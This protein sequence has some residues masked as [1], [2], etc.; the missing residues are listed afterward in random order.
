MSFR[1][2]DGAV[3]K[4]SANGHLV[5]ITRLLSISKIQTLLSAFTEYDIA[6]DAKRW[7]N[8]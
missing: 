7:L 5:F 4:I 8:V 6:G 3:V 1:A 2:T